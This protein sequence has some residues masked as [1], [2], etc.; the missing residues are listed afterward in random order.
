MRYMRYDI[1]YVRYDK[2]YDI[3]YD[4]IYVMIYDMIY[5]MVW[6]DISCEVTSINS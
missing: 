4:M 2:R 6:Y 3:I 5:D 1:W